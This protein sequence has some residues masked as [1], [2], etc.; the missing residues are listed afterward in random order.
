MLKSLLFLTALLP[1]MA[2][3]QSLERELLLGSS[4]T[5]RRTPGADTY[6]FEVCRSNQCQALG[7]PGGY[8]SEEIR[9]LDGRWQ[10]AGALLL[11]TGEALVIAYTGAAAAAVGAAYEFAG[12]V[13]FGV[14][15]VAVPTVA[16]TYID[17]INPV[18]H[19]K[20]GGTK[21]RMEN[22]L[23]TLIRDGAA[24]VVLYRSLNPEDVLE[25]SNRVEAVLLSL[26]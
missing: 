4:I 17:A 5:I 7:D 22:K 15:G 20:T 6:V 11:G 21:A 12:M 10:Q 16:V 3:G 23:N 13:A 24:G 26:R 25:M 19:F 14:A 18:S 9:S 2:F 8:T 1:A